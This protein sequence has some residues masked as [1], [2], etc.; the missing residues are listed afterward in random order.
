MKKFVLTLIV[1]AVAAFGFGADQ[2]HARGPGETAAADFAEQTVTAA[3][4]VEREK[5][6]VRQTD[7]DIVSAP[8]GNEK[9]PP[10]ALK[11]FS[12]SRTEQALTARNR[13]LFARNDYLPAMKP[14]ELSQQ[15]AF[16]NTTAP[17]D[18][19]RGFGFSNYARARI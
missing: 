4:S 9:R 5:S 19:F 13:I 8:T 15:N 11:T 18:A 16:Y 14:S 7:P 10:A 17:P 12:F 2:Y 1:I 6:V 3:A